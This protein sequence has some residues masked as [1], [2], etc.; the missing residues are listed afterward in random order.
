MEKAYSIRERLKNKTRDGYDLSAIKNFDRQRNLYLSVKWASDP[1]ARAFW[2]G[3]TAEYTWPG[4]VVTMQQDAMSNIH[5]HAWYSFLELI[6]PTDYRCQKMMTKNG[7]MWKATWYQKD[8]WSQNLYGWGDG[9]GSAVLH[10]IAVLWLMEIEPD[11]E[12]WF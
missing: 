4:N 12:W 8:N 3:M 6:I 2:R 10:L 1:R 5:R 7:L 9:K 11:L